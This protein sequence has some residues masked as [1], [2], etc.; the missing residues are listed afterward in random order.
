MLVE[1][2]QLLSTVCEALVD[3]RA[4]YL[5]VG[6]LK[7]QIE[8]C[9]ELLPHRSQKGLM[10]ESDPI[11]PPARGVGWGMDLPRSSI[12]RDTGGQKPSLGGGFASPGF[13]HLPG[14]CVQPGSSLCLAGET[15]GGIRHL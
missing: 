4:A 7:M 6:P 1:E 9:A 11:I 2:V 5:D 15:T 3:E 14:I 8:T 12:R 13:C 10:E